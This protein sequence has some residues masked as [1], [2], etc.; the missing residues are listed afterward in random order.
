M[1]GELGAD[2][3]YDP[4]FGLNSPMLTHFYGGD[5]TIERIDREAIRLD[6]FSRSQ[7][8]KG[9]V[10]EEQRAVWLDGLEAWRKH[11]YVEA[12]A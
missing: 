6:A 1:L 9:L 8:A 4:P 3:T 12:G 11:W 2:M 10:T 5:L 7:V